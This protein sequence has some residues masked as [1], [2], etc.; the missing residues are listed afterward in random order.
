MKQT[1]IKLKY[2]DARVRA[3]RSVF[4]KKNTTLEVEMLDA[5]SQMYK[6][7][8]K[9]EVRDFIEEMEEQNNNSS[10]KQK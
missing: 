8:V 6:K 4:T 5:L 3:L 2:P 10:I 7:N 9:P 1:E